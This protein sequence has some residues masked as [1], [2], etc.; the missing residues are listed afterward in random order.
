[1]RCTQCQFE[2]PAGMRFCGGCGA[3]LA[4]CCP[5]CGAEN[6][7]G[8]KFCG[9]CGAA[10]AAGGS[11]G[12]PPAPGD[13]P[14]ARPADPSPKSYTPEHLSAKI[15][16][17]RAAMEGERKQVTVL[18]CDLVG[19][20]SIA[21]RLGPEVMHEALNRFFK[22]ALN[23]VH[24][25]EGTINQFLGD[26]F[27]ALFGAPIAHEDHTVRAVL[28]AVGLRDALAEGH[29]DLGPD[30]A[31][32]QVRM[33][34]NCGPV[35][36]GGIGDNL[37]MDYTAVGDTTNL[38]ARL[39][40]L[41][42]P[43]SILASET[44]E[45]LAQRHF[46]LEPLPPA[47]VKGKT[48][49]I[50]A[51]RVGAAR[52]RRSSQAKLDD[53]TLSP[54][55]G[56]DREVAILRE[57]MEQVE[58]G[59]G[60]AVGVAG[61]AGTGKSR[62]LR[63]FRHSLWGRKVAYMTAHCRSY[64]TSL[65]YQPLIHAFRGACRIGDGDDQA[66][67][68]RKV[69]RNIARIEVESEALT[70][71]LYL[72]GVH[73]ARER[74]AA[75]GPLAIKARIL[76]SLQQVLL[77]ISQHMPLV[78]EIDD[79]QWVDESSEEFLTSMVE[80]IAG[81]PVMLL[82]TY[83]TGYRPGWLDKSYATQINLRQ[84]TR[85]DSLALVNSVLLRERLPPEVAK[86]ILDKGE[87]NPFFL[88]ELALTMMQR[89]PV[90]DALAVPDTIQDLL[91]ARI[92]RLDASQ[93]LVLQTASV[94][95]REFP[96]PLLAAIWNADRPLEPLL[97]ELKR[98][99][100]LYQGVGARRNY[101]FKHV[102]IR[103]VS[104][105]TLLTGRRQALHG[106][107]ADALERLFAGR[108]DEVYAP[109]ARHCARA[110]RFA[111]AMRFLVLQADQAG[112]VYAH[113]EAA[114]CLREALGHAE[115]LPREVRDRS[116]FEVALRLTETLLPLARFNE[117]LELLLA[118]QER[119]ERLASPGLTGPYYFWLSHTYSYL[120]QPEAATGAAE[121]SLAEAR[122]CNDEVTLGKAHYV[123]AREG[124]WL[125]RVREGLDQGAAALS[126]LRRHEDRWWRGQALWVT[127]FNQFVLGQ[128]GPAL[129]A[130]AEAD[131][132]GR[133]LE[134]PRLYTSWS[135]GYLLASMG[136][137]AAGVQAC[138]QGQAEATD[139]LNL[140]AARGFLGFAY[141]EQG[142]IQRA[143]GLLHL[144]VDVLREAGF[145]Q[146]LSWFKAFLAEALGR[147]GDFDQARSV[148]GHGLAIARDA[149]FCLGVGLC[150]KAQGRIALAAGEPAGPALEEAL[151]TFESM[152][153]PFEAA[154]VRL[155][156]AAL[157]EEQGD[158][159][160]ATSFLK[161]A[162]EA[163]ERLD[164]TIYLE[165]ARALARRFDLA[166]SS[167]PAMMAEAG[168][169]VPAAEAD[170]AAGRGAGPLPRLAD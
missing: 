47:F 73:E 36:V 60:Q 114:A 48:F 70:P 150:Q 129:A 155:D 62:L 87:G 27:M 166:A 135:S 106:A 132:I 118:Q 18:F 92:D 1:M 31:G 111:E 64:S 12:P 131:G 54:F 74:L 152:D 82:V 90:A 25:Y 110:E 45:K 117:T 94:L 35:V 161:P 98:Q 127:G 164:A 86:L 159:A 104:Y 101:F 34:L 69:E 17:S 165:R 59:R 57:A 81:A 123:L 154:K 156:L 67:I 170:G 63:E 137:C 46:Q 80:T 7:P 51:F 15:L 39:Q 5:G 93:K 20:T 105:E 140:A 139:P 151:A 58:A 108:L 50:R 23:E 146:L 138:E 91:M 56:R 14:G 72:L 3:V 68:S 19:S 142:E 30:G 102:L 134:D 126:L 33:G 61:E 121:R 52:G 16:R 145:R 143:G 115:R 40:Q 89:T 9:Q 8:F 2:N 85:E 32:F 96:L 41:A 79:L 100:F 66:T 124:F 95:G 26:G 167:P 49:P 42:E 10:L 78:I 83:R 88:E 22:L 11:P 125:G 136:D 119:V 160:A 112:R 130:M 77:K 44:V 38:A 148:A 24:R 107:A 169:A 4:S 29:A 162:I 147:G 75:M 120:G 149:R 97:V 128:L 113:A 141:L 28:A 37:R 103:D 163:L 71:L 43:G 168:V 122:G 6:P 53:A 116:S 157:A 99:E 65:P 55:V 144:A 153:A 158:G 133:E 76:S 84:L 21:E 109:L 13:R